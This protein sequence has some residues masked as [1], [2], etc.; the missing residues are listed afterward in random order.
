MKGDD[1]QYQRQALAL[2]QQFFQYVAP[3]LMLISTA[4][5]LQYL[6]HAMLESYRFARM[7]GGAVATSGLLFP[8]LFFDQH[9]ESAYVALAMSMLLGLLL[10]NGYLCAC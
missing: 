10:G 6:G 1:E 7:L 8:A 4:F 2:K 3:C 5:T 9:K